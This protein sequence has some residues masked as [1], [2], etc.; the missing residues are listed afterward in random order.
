MNTTSCSEAV[1]LLWE[2]LDGLLDEPDRAKVSEHLAHCRKCCGEVDFLHELRR[3]LA[4]A[5]GGDDVPAPA[6]VMR[7]LNQTLDGLG[8]PL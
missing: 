8:K 5:G 2:Y 1:R 3:V 7:R 4:E 6:D